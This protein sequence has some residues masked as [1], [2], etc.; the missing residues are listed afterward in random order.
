MMAYFCGRNL[1]SSGKIFYLLQIDGMF[2]KEPDNLSELSA[3]II[4]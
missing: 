4:F 3:K 2:Y 1:D